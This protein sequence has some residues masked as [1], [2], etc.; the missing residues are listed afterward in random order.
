[1]A[2]C[3]LSIEIADSQ[4]KYFGGQTVRGTVV[5]RVDS[6]V[7]CKGLQVQTAWATH[8][9]G[10]ID[11]GVGESVILFEGEWTAGETYR[12]DFEL[13]VARWPPTYHGHYLN[14]DHAV[15]ARASIP[16]SFDPKASE[17]IHVTAVDGPEAK[18]DSSTNQATGAA[19]AGCAIVGTVFVGIFLVVM[20]L[21]P[22]A[23]ILAGIV[24][25]VGGGWW[26]FFRYLPRVA[27][28]KVQYQLQT[29]RLAPGEEVVGELVLRPKRNVRLN[30]IVWKITAEEVCVSGS[31]SNRT[32]RRHS[33][34]E[35]E[36]EVV[37]ATTLTAEQ[38]TRIP[39]RFTLP[40]QPFYSLDL[41]DNDLTWNTHLRVDIPRWPDYVD[42]ASF[43]VVPDVA[44]GSEDRP[45]G[46]SPM[47]MPARVGV[48]PR[49]SAEPP[50]LTF[51][52]TVAHVWASRGDAEQTDMLVGA[53]E[54]I[55]FDIEAIIER[56]LLYGNDDPA[57]Y[58]D[59]YVVWGHY[60]D[61]E[62]PLTLYIPKHLGDEFE[63][64][65]SRV[66]KGRG[67]ITGYDRRHGRL[68]VHV[69]DH[70]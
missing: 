32:T 62:L 17:L 35:Q 30:R 40:D 22:F 68:Q 64:A 56:R 20:L 61:P 3:D 55:P 27:L 54:G 24:G 33:L 2:K 67:R 1:V 51:A 44:T 63:Q 41:S 29:N 19:G 16:W 46:L 10:N 28:G 4:D 14:V 6:D 59:G 53:V 70:V 39:L 37:G 57:A 50:A 58:R 26:V 66:W 65:G 12:Y 36:L 15:E 38:E 47:E 31:G 60:P 13:K 52:E 18:L 11:Q 48:A 49:Q 5:V 34:H 23:W 43:L 45:D 42:K 21:N 7:R 8:G 69:E 9:Y 25:L